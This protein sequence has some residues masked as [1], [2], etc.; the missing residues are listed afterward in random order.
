M[1]SFTRRSDNLHTPNTRKCLVL[2]NSAVLFF[3]I[4]IP[5]ISKLQEFNGKIILLPFFFFFGHND[6]LSIIYTLKHIHLSL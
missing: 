5:D 1:S 6:K 4:T 3:S 2:G